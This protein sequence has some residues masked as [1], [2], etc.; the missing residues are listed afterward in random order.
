MKRYP[1]HILFLDFTYSYTFW[2]KKIPHWYTFEVKMIPIHI[3]GGL[4]SIPHSSRTSVYTFIMNVTPRPR[5]RGAPTPPAVPVIFFDKFL[6]RLRSIATHRD[7]FVRR[8]S[9]RPSVTL[10]CH[11]FQSYVSQ[12]THAFLG[13]LP[14]LLM[15]KGGQAGVVMLLAVL[16]LPAFHLYSWS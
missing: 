8:L 15:S 13:M 2:A 12:A 16:V 11:T 1:I 5:G 9:V 6:C 14:L 7:H 10:F 3:L 4:K